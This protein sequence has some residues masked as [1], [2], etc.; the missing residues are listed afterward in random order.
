MERKKYRVH[1]K[2]K[3][4]NYYLDFSPSGET[5]LAIEI[6]A[7]YA[8]NRVYPEVKEEDIIRINN[9]NVLV[10]RLFHKYILKSQE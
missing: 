6:S 5:G 3:D 9:L 2:R 10:I 1:Y 8:I 4:G 7:I